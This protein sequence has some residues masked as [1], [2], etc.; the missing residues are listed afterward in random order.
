MEIDA[1]SSH[2]AH[3][4][5]L[6]GLYKAL[7][8]ISAAPP[9]IQVWAGLLAWRFELKTGPATVSY[10]EAGAV[11]AL[12]VFFIKPIYAHSFRLRRVTRIS[13]RQCIVPL[14][15]HAKKICAMGWI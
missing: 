14:S 3:P 2:N 1:H 5:P 11:L 9:L 15:T 13:K 6:R 10:L 8:V 4:W 12:V 7:L